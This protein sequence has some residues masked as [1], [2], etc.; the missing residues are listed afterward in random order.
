M[1]EVGA[2]LVSAPRHQLHFE[3][4]KPLFP[5]L[6]DNAVFC[7]HSL[8]VEGLFVIDGDGLSLF[9]AAVVSGEPS[10]FAFG[11]TDGHAEVSLV[12]LAV[13]HLLVHDA[14][15][16]GGLGADNDTFGIT[17]DAVAEGGGEALFRI[18]AVAALIV[19]VMESAV[20]EGIGRTALIVVDDQSDGLMEEQD[21]LVLEDDD[22]LRGSGEEAVFPARPLKEFVVDVE[23][24]DVAFG[25]FLGDIKAFAVEFDAFLA[26]IFIHSTLRQS[27]ASLTNKLIR[28]LTRVIFTDNEF[29]HN[30]S[31]NMI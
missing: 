21:I 18:G 10:L 25:E 14:E 26:D 5:V 9:I 11:D 31:N 29:S 17:V 8:I 22:G 7:H 23:S 16:F 3:E 13:A 15:G 1:S 20:D 28:P 4:R 2:Y 30:N 19:E 12:K 24:H 6:G 27:G